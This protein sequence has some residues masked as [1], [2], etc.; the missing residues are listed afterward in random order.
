M[1]VAGRFGLGAGVSVGSGAMDAGFT[2]V[3]PPGFA[4]P[5]AGVLSH[6]ATWVAIAAGVWLGIMYLHFHTY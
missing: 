3:Q 4:P 5:P 1:A 2:Q 6:G